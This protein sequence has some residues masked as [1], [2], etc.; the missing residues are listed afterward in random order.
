MG[1]TGVGAVQARDVP[2]GLLL[3]QS[4]L[5]VSLCENHH[6]SIGV[7]KIT[8]NKAKYI[9]GICL[10]DPLSQRASKFQNS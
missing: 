5:H 2:N 8:L 4:S 6:V 3:R 7:N 9:R 10:G 1:D